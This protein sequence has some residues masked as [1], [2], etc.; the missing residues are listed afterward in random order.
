MSTHPTLGI[1]GSKPRLP[2]SEGN[3]SPASKEELSALNHEYLRSRNSQMASKSALA[4]MELARMRGALLDKKWVYDSVAY[5]VTCWRQRCLLSPRTFTTRLVA[6]GLIDAANEHG[7][8]MA[9]DAGMRELLTELAN[10]ELKATNPNWLR[11][12]ERKEIGTEDEPERQQT[13]DE[14]RIEQAR[15]ERRRQKKT[16]TMR[17]LRAA[18]RV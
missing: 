7:V 10:L 5:V 9:L 4:E 18:G 14:H 11:T 1:A 8:L 13:P 16:E 12:L 6:S 3:G 15:V 17:E 2:K